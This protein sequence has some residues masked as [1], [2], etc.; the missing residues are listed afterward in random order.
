MPTH[1]DQQILPYTREQLF[2][3][4]ADIEK[5]PEFLPWCRAARVIS[6]K[7]GELTAE[8]MISFKHLSES[9]VSCVVLDRPHRIEATLVRGP[10]SHL[11]NRWTFTQQP[12]GATQVDFYVDF[13]FRSRMLE[14]LI[15]GF[16]TRAS[17][18]MGE[19]FKARA[20]A[21]YG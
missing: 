1:S 15:G 7:E 10:F 21:L 6:R 20:Q 14:M 11:I 17:E 13:A 4:V 16:F 12:G 2:D 19:A 5:Y 3:L 8:L 9:Y 18:K